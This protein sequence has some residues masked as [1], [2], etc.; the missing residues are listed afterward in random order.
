[1]KLIGEPNFFSK[2]FLIRCLH[3]ALESS[4]LQ[5]QPF[6][7][8]KIW[9]PL[10]ASVHCKLKIFLK[11]DLRFPFGGSRCAILHLWSPPW[12]GQHPGWAWWSQRSK[13]RPSCR[14]TCPAGTGRS[15]CL[16]ARHGQT[17]R[18]SQNLGNSSTY[19]R[20]T[21]QEMPPVENRQWF[22]QEWLFRFGRNFDAQH[23][24]LTFSTFL[25]KSSIFLLQKLKSLGWIFSDKF[26]N[27]VQICRA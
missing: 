17:T 22:S 1:M 16:P 13:C 9:C 5:T 21:S 10:S 19:I 3:D 24:Y 8:Y 7:S 18:R 12:T 27:P 23:K 25:I 4:D 15:P 11:M 20:S 26:V 2:L 6:L 14:A